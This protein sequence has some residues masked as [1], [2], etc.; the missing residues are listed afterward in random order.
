MKKLLACTLALT[1]TAAMLTACG[2][3]D[4]S[5]S[6]KAAATTTTTT[7]ET[8][9]TTEAT[10]TT[11]AE[12]AAESTADSATESG[13]AEEAKDISEMPATLASID[14]ASVKFKTDMNAEDFV[15]PM[16]EKDWD[17]TDESHVNLTIEEVAGVP[18]VKCEVLDVNDAGTGY[19]I[20]KIRF[21]MAKLFEGQEEDLE[22]IFTV[23]ADVVTK[24][25]GNFTADDGTE[26]LVPGNFMG[27]F[28]TQTGADPEEL[29]WNDLYDF[30][31][32]EWTSEWGSYELTMRPGIKAGVATFS[33]TTTE[34]YVTI[35]RWSIPNDACFYIA[36]LTFEDE[37]GNVIL[38]KNFQ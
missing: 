38:C 3:T 31:E 1:M 34:Q 14:T 8:T 17:G 11:A 32:S 15:A 25:V 35:M 12:S 30:G 13:A 6:S 21:N 29:S 4:D 26:S 33:N 24:A 23:K 37:D 22:K 18:M 27:A 36:D 10:T 2:S 9:T 5:S 28:C 16:A 7:A 20:P 19:K